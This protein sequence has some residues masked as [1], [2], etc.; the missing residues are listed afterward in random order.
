MTRPDDD[1]LMLAYVY[2]ELS[3]EEA[4]A[5]EARLSA[6]PGLRAE[7]DGLLATRDLLQQDARYGEVTGADLPPPHLLDAILRAEALERPPEVRQAQASSREGGGFLARIQLWLVGG[8]LAV[9]AAAALL[10][11]TKGAMEAPEAAAEAP[12]LAP[13]PPAA[14]AREEE[15]AAEGAP[16][17]GALGARGAVSSSAPERKSSLGG[18]FDDGRS[19]GLEDAQGGGA[20]PGGGGVPASRAREAAPSE[21]RP[22]AEGAKKASKAQKAAPADVT[23]AKPL[24]QKSV[25]KK[26]RAIGA[27]DGDAYA[28]DA[29][30]EAEAGAEAEGPAPAAE[31]T[32]LAL[33]AASGRATSTGSAPAASQSP[34]PLADAEP[35]G[36]PPLPEAAKR[37]LEAR[38]AE[39]S[40]AARPLPKGKTPGSQA[41]ADEL[42]LSLLTAERELQEGRP[43]EALDLFV[44]V[45]KRDPR[46][47]FTGV[48]PYVGQM[49]ALAAL[50]RHREVLALL[51]TVKRPGIRAHGVPEGI[52]VAA[53]SAEALGDL[54]LARSLYRELL[55]VKEQRTEAAAALQRLDEARAKHRADSAASEPAKAA[56]AEE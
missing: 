37:E 12:A 5:F 2:G 21:P 1:S 55:A 32:P 17:S 36:P 27:G 11:M 47:V 40:P 42:Q 52:L 54:T 22:M 3:D 8:G 4:R 50:G 53:R 19:K 49:R 41:L 7:V 33:D 13:A 14:M 44:A 20:A 43:L 34:R 24:V 16:P 30:F 46:G 45:S 18:S 25:Q 29:A 9:G 10:V 38:R 31:A 39:R 15:P 51:P 6:D 48:V 23:D 56:P 28:D 26:E 35:K